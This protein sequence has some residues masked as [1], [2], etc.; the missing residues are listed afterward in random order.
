MEENIDASAYRFFFLNK[1][2]IKEER[3]NLHGSTTYWSTSIKGV[4]QW[5]S[6][7]DIMD[8]TAENIETDITL[9]P[10]FLKNISMLQLHFWY[11]K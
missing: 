11:T 1:D 7:Q 5:F 2:S 9:L 3:W 8:Y 6:L 10:S 4:I